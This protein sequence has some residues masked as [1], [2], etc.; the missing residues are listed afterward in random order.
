MRDAIREATATTGPWVGNAH[1]RRLMITYD[2]L[3][4]ECAQSF[5][6]FT[7]FVSQHNVEQ[8]VKWR[9]SRAVTVE[10]GDTCA[11][12]CVGRVATHTDRNI[13]ITSQRLY[14]SDIG[15]EVTIAALIV[16]PMAVVVFLF[17]RRQFRKR[18]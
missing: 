4:D 18:Q 16:G 2:E 14:G 12:W 3:T 7:A 1:I 10:R 6:S 5:A 13:D 9:D 15:K 11:A 17:V 8:A